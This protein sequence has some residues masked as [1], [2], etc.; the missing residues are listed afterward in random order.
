MTSLSIILIAGVLSMASPNVLED[1]A[2]RRM[3]YGWMEQDDITGYQA[4]LATPS[5]DHVGKRGR[6][7]VGNRAYSALVVDCA[8]PE[9]RGAMVANGLLADV[10]VPELVHQKG[11]LIIYE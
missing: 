5:C 7:I 3:H 9:H 11:V 1:V 6:L 4:L 2:H 10:N 8:Q